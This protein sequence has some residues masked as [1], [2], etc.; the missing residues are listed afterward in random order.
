MIVNEVVTGHAY[1]DFDEVMACKGDDQAF[2]EL[3]ISKARGIMKHV[4]AEI[5]DGFIEG[6][7]DVIAFLK[8]NFNHMVEAAANP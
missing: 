7:E 2:A 5:E 4:I 3:L 8:A 1:S 6:E